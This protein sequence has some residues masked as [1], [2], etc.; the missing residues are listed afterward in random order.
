[1]ADKTF[2]AA[3]GANI[4]KAHFYRNTAKELL[5]GLLK[6]DKT[7]NDEGKALKLFMAREA[8]TKALMSTSEGQKL[9]LDAEAQVVTSEF[10]D[11]VEEQIEA[12]QGIGTPSNFA[13][14][15]DELTS[16]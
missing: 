5:G 10:M 13:A 8:L 11:S 16:L 14:R 3:C 1:M 2:L 4:T 7:L 12:A 9:L 15:V 6:K